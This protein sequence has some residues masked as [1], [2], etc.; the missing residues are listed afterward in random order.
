MVRT[1]DNLGVDVSTRYAED[2]KMADAQFLKETRLISS[3]TEIDVTVPF[4]PSEFDLLFETSR[5]N[6]PWA[7][8]YAP[9]RYNEQKKRLFTFQIIPSMGSSDKIEAQLQRIAARVPKREEKEEAEEKDKERRRLKW[10]KEK[11]E[12]EEEK[13]KNIL[14]NLLNSV[15]L[16][17]KFLVDINS[18][19]GQYQRG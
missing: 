17:D 9:P 10:E 1:I 2:Q 15:S 18:R 4:F 6:T 12:E 13:E 19:R 11:E 16:F 14:I 8:F 3:Q 7:D 5:R